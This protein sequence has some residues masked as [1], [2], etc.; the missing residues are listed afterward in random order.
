MKKTTLILFSRKGCCLCEGLQQRLQRIPLDDLSPSIELQVIDIDYQ[1][2]TEIQ[3]AHYELRVPVLAVRSQNSN[4][5]LE[6][7]RVSPRL[8]EEGLLIWLQNAI[9]KAFQSE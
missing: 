6:L 3:R 7:P 8:N 2:I 5:L 1:G 9:T 4:L